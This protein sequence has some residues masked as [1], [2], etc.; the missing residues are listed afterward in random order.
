[1]IY[2]LNTSQQNGQTDPSLKV[3]KQASP[4]VPIKKGQAEEQA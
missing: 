4:Q 3:S 1:M 2:K